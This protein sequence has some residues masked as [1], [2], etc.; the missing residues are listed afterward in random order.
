[1]KKE[2][3]EADAWIKGSGPQHGPAEAVSPSGGALGQGAFP[4]GDP[5]AFHDLLGATDKLKKFLNGT[6]G[7]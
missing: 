2:S 3:L 6:V 1:M 5:A 4:R 7:R